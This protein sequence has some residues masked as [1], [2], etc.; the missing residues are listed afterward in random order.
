MF[1]MYVVICIDIIIVTYH[2]K[3]NARRTG[4]TVSNELCLPWLY[5]FTA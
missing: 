3:K 2:A 4:R 1:F 5:R